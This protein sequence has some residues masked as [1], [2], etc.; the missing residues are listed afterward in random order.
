MNE[1]RYC[2]VL[3]S[4][5]CQKSGGEKRVI[6]VTSESVDLLR[7]CPHNESVLVLKRRIAH[8]DVCAIIVSKECTQEFTIKAMST[9][10][11]RLESER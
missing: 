1:T 9:Y 10:D 2:Q 6:V 5:R 8:R 4:A 11:I 3:I 7:H